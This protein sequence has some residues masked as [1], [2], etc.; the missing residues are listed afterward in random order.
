[1]NRVVAALVL[2]DG[3]I[4][5]ADDT[6]R[7]MFYSRD[8]QYIGHFGGPGA[9]PG[10]FERISCIGLERQKSRGSAAPPNTSTREWARGSLR[11]YA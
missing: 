5:V 9:G 11:V 7:V 10:E 2:G 8:G 1:M 6:Q 4:V 3:R